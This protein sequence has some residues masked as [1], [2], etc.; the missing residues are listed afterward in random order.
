MS[1]F[2][3]I[4][5]VNREL[6][7]AVAEEMAKTFYEIVWRPPSPMRRWPFCARSGPAHPAASTRGPPSAARTA[8]DYRRISGGFLVQEPDAYADDSIELKVVTQRGPERGG[9]G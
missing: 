5:A 6:T 1:A 4:V 3:G 8:P 9:G 7:E 2:G